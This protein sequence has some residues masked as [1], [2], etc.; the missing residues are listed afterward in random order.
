MKKWTVS[1]KVVYI[2]ALILG[3]FA[4]VVLITGFGIWITKNSSNVASW[5][6]AIGSIGAVLA[7]FLGIQYQN[8]ITAIQEKSE[9]LEIAREIRF[10]NALMLFQIYLNSEYYS[11]M[12]LWHIQRNYFD[13]SYF[14]MHLKIAQDEFEVVDVYKLARSKDILNIISM[15]A[16]L[17][18]TMSLVDLDYCKYIDSGKIGDIDVHVVQNLS[19]EDEINPSRS[20]VM[21][22]ANSLIRMRMRSINIYRKQAEIVISESKPDERA[23]MQKIM[24][25]VVT[26]R[27]QQYQLASPSDTGRPQ[28]PQQ[29]AASQ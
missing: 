25:E 1:E 2:W 26:S 17:L 11:R 16:N 5:V 29:P 22:L 10:R 21:H 6:Q 27:A 15:K 7:V 20:A 12:I 28:T 9:Q 4:S 24:D 23:E 13:W 14:L 19:K 3:T 18:S 8:H